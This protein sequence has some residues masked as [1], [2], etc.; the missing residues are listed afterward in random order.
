VVLGPNSVEYRIQ[1]EAL[2][3]GGGTCT[4][5]DIAVAARL[6]RTDFCSCPEKVAS[7][8]AAMVYGSMREIHQKLEVIIDSMKVRK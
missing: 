6:S 4:T 2:C 7:L 1:Q 5:T 8:P 3:F